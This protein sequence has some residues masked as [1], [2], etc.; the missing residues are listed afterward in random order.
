VSSGFL[1]KKIFFNL[2]SQKNLRNTLIILTNQS[3][4]LEYPKIIQNYKKKNENKILSQSRSF[5]VGK[6]KDKKNF[7]GTHFIK[8][9]MLPLKMACFDI[10]IS[11]IINFLF[12]FLFFSDFLF[13]LKPTTKK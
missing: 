13:P 3:T 4:N 10:G 1:D 2:F 9:N 5:L 7:K 12:P 8:W 11:S 6:E